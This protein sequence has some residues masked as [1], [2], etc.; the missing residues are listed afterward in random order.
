MEVTM[1]KQG[2]SKGNKRPWRSDYEKRY[3]RQALAQ[4]ALLLI[5]YFV[6]ML[7]AFTMLQK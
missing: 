6:V 7:I 5:L 4:G 1:R 2:Y 3:F